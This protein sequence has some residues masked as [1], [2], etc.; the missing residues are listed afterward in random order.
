MVDAMRLE[1]GDAFDRYTIDAEI[2]EGG[3]GVVYRATDTKLHRSV[4]LK[5]LRVDAGAVGSSEAAEARAR[6]V[7]E[8]RAAASLDHANAVAIFDVGEHEGVPYL[9]NLDR[10]SNVS[11]TATD[12]RS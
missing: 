6:L 9:A 2:G 8:A 7:R 3:M 5:L 10:R 11:G 4:A 1:P 12:I